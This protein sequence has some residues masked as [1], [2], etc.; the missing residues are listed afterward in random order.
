[1]AQET[2][3][4]SLVVD[5]HR[6]EEGYLAYFPALP[7]CHTWAE[8]YE[9]A[10]E[11]AEEALSATSKRSPKPAEKSPSTIVRF[12]GVSLGITL[13]VPATA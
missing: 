13:E 7:G 10:V 4:Y 1:M 5:F 6:D 9:D 8:N 11:R 3:T 2:R 12:A